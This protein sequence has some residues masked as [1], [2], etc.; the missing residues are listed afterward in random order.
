M[1]TGRYIVVFDPPFKDIHGFSATQIYSEEQGSTLDNVVVQSIENG[2]VQVKTG[3]SSG[4]MRDR[5][6]TFVAYGEVA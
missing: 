6:F 5:E 4:H 2:Q 3:D 1:E